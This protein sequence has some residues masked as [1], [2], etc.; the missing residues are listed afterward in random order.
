[1]GI[2]KIKEK[3][4]VSN[5][6]KEK[7]QAA[8]KELLRRGLLTGTEKLNGQLRDA[9]EGGQRE[10]T[11]VERAQ[12]SA[13]T[14]TQKAVNQLK[15]TAHKKKKVRN[16]KSE[17][18]KDTGRI[19]S[20][21]ST[22]VIQT[23]QA[24][25]SVSAEAVQSKTK[26]TVRRA[27]SAEH[28]HTDST[29]FEASQIK[30]KDARIQSQTANPNQKSAAT[31]AAPS[32][33]QT[34]HTLQQGQQKYVRERQKNAAEQ[35]VEKQRKQERAAAARQQS[36]GDVRPRHNTT[37]S[38][39]NGKRPAGN[40]VRKTVSNGKQRIKE[41]RS[42]AKAVGRTS[43][44][45]V[46]TAESSGKALRAGGRSV[47][48]MRQTARAAVQAKQQVIQAAGATRRTAATVGRP[49]ARAAAAALAMGLPFGL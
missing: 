18:H 47:Q 42:E 23:E 33:R 24:E 12:N 19:R 10:E 9:A 22:P 45:A 1:M 31:S 41:A 14:T 44:Q 3:P 29:R 21:V 34:P 5:S 36:T 35:R 32:T 7:I 15:K 48:T 30:T 28:R 17:T 26:G 4:S 40:V 6:A 38:A 16:G 13:R 37:Q 2:Q 49:M 8:P 25:P 11:E 43:R 39:Q 46:K 20:D 27:P